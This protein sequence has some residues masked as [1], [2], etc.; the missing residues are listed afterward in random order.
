M[1]VKVQ[2]ALASDA[3][4]EHARRQIEG[5]TDGLNEQI[6]QITVDLYYA[7]D[8]PGACDKVC[9][10]SVRLRPKGLLDVASTGG[11][12]ASAI[13]MAARKLRVHLERGTPA[14]NGSTEFR[15]VTRTG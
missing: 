12:F 1:Q 8:S 10:I 3:I 9:R 7:D 13:D 15:H 4:R 6:E 5:A 11:H 14:R 2:N